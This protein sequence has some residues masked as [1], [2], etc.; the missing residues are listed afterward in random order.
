MAEVYL[1]GVQIYRNTISGG[2][3]IV[4]KKIGVVLDESKY[5]ED[6]LK[7]RATMQKGISI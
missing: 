1:N 4:T 2:N 7:T 6:V 5:K 3:R